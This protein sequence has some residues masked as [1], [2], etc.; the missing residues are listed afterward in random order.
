MAIVM[1]KSKPKTDDYMEHLEAYSAVGVANV[2]NKDGSK[3]FLNETKVVIPNIVIPLHELCRVTAGGGHTINLGNYESAKITVEISMPC[4]K[5]DL[6]ETYDF[7][8]DWVSSKMEEAVKSA[9]A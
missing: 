4:R 1:K 2:T 7:C 9:K 6:S 8:T 5:Q 3:T